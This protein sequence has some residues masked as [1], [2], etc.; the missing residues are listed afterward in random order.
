MHLFWSKQPGISQF[1]EKNS[2]NCLCRCASCTILENPC[3][4]EIVLSLDKNT[5]SRNSNPWAGKIDLLSSMAL[6]TGD[7]H[8]QESLERD[9]KDTFEVKWKICLLPASASGQGN[10]F[11]PF[12]CPHPCLFVLECHF[13][14]ILH[15]NK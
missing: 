13:E 6:P 14:L 12:E 9:P 5:S 7:F 8:F 1:G 3:W 2:P 11:D 4:M 15:K 10:Q